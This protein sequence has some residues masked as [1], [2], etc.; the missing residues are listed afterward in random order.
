MFPEI[1]EGEHMPSSRKSPVASY[2]RRMKR[3]GFVRVEVR[4]RDEDAPLLRSVARALAD[5]ERAGDARGL[6]RQHFMQPSA[7]GLKDL[8]AAAPLDGIDL[9]RSRETGRDV[10]L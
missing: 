8:L 5:P 6:L 1:L 4:V 7:K 3:E 2:R 9:V 10:D